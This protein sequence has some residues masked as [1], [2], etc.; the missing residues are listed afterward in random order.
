M[1]LAVDRD[2]DA[3]HRA[4]ELKNTFEKENNP[5]RI[6]PV[7][8]KFSRLSQS[9]PKEIMSSKFDLI[10]FDFGVSSFQLDSAQ[11]GF[12]FRH[13]GPLD[14]RMS[15]DV[16]DSRGENM[17]DGLTAYHIVNYYSPQQIQSILLKYGEEEFAH[18]IT[19]EIIRRRQAKPIATTHELR[20]LIV[21]VYPKSYLRKT[22]YFDPNSTKSHPATKT[23]QAL[24]IEVNNE[25]KEIERG[26]KQAEHLLTVGSGLFAAVTFHSLEDKMVKSYL[27]DKSKWNNV[28][29]PIMP[30]DQEIKDNPRCRSGKLRSGVLAV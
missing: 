19:E 30:S 20:D 18:L 11:R 4:Q 24:R 25:L 12:S 8:C 21:D 22:G 15:V 10:V 3:F 16:G 13:D 7:N 1:V 23:F 5:T 28:H 17:D 26:L 6:V 27:G 29:H 14:M 9:I 2:I